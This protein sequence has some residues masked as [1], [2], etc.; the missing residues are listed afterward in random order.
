MKLQYPAY[1]L[2]SAS[3]PIA[4]TS[5]SDDLKVVIEDQAKNAL[6]SN[7]ITILLTLGVTVAVI[8]FIYGKHVAPMLDKAWDKFSAYLD[9]NT[10]TASIISSTTGKID[11]SLADHRAQTKENLGILTGKLDVLERKIDQ[12]RDEITSIKISLAKGS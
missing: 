2:T 8:Y 5:I 7:S 11:G 12:V 1:F 3:A 10:N 4:S 9:S 6:Q